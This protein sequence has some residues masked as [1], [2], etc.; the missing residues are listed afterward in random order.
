MKYGD[1][2]AILHCF[3]QNMGFQSYF[4]KG[5]YSVKNKKKAYLSPLNEITFTTNSYIKSGITNISK[6]EQV[7]SLDCQAD[8]RASAII[9]FIA[10]FLHQVLKKETKQDIVYQEIKEFLFQLENKNYQAHF[11]F[12]LNF[13]KLQGVAPLL[14]G[15]DFL[16]PESGCFEVVSCHQLF[17]KDISTEWK[18]FI[19][20]ENIYNIKLKNTIKEEFLDSVLV[21]YY[22]HFPEFKAP[23]SLEVLRAIFA[24]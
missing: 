7:K 13:L 16:D 23:K 10:E 9:F 2:D 15:G 21:Y 3:T 17:N 6:I 5:I 12:L 4:I 14:G 20:E 1:N 22:C 8:V 19:S 18:N 24:E 11:A